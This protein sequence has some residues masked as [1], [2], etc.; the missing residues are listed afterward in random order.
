MDNSELFEEMLQGDDEWGDV[1]QASLLEDIGEELEAE[2]DIPQ[3]DLLTEKEGK[4]QDFH[5]YGL[6][7]L[8]IVATTF[9]NAL[10]FDTNDVRTLSIVIG[11]FLLIYAGIQRIRSKVYWHSSM[12]MSY[13]A[14]SNR[15]SAQGA[16][17]V[18]FGIAEIALAVMLAIL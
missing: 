12:P 7:V 18:L 1:P 10:F 8:S 14:K 5:F 9:I 17:A 6:I 2:A 16:V 11:G 15:K 4:T 3:Y 13:R